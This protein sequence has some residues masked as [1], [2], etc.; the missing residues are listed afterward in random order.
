MRTVLVRL[1]G[2]VAIVLAALLTYPSLS[3]LVVHEQMDTLALI[4]RGALL[5]FAAGLAVRWNVALR[6]AAALLLIGAL[7][8]PLGVWY[9]F[10]AVDGVELTAV[11]A[12]LVWFIPVELFMLLSAWVLDLDPRRFA[13]HES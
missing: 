2:I 5:L 7:L 8:L 1:R 13:R 3:A 12:T 4:G 11:S 6:V 10:A 9:P